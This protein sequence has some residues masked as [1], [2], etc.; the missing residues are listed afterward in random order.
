MSSLVRS[1]ARL[2]HLLK[3]QIEQMKHSLYVH[4]W[5]VWV[6]GDNGKFLSK[7]SVCSIKT[8]ALPF[9]MMLTVQYNQAAIRGLA[10]LS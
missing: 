4:G 7:G 6:L 1:N 10:P 5:W 2:G 9:L 8:K 3:E